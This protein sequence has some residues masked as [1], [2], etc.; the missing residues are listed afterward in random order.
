MGSSEKEK[1]FVVWYE[2]VS[3]GRF[4]ANF[5][6]TY[7]FCCCIFYFVDKFLCSGILFC[8]CGNILYKVFSYGISII[9]FICSLVS[10]GRR[11]RGLH[12]YY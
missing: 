5:Y 7:C 10:S 1:C 8:R 6:F 11:N 2:V 12:G 3:L 9:F 4:E